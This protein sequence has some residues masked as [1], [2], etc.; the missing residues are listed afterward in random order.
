MP[1]IIGGNVLINGNLTS[2]SE[3]IVEGQVEGDIRGVNVTIGDNAIV[4]GAIIADR[5]SVHGQIY[6]T[7]RAQHI[8]LGPNSHV[9]ATI[10][11]ETLAIEVGAYFQGDCRHSNTPLEDEAVEARTT[12]SVVNFAL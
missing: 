10:V 1:S 11:Q 8:A 6:G 4:K 12:S 3:I 7:I 2:A 5:V 9:E